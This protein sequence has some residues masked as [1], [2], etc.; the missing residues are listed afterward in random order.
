M[1]VIY[2]K[3]LGL[4]VLKI[5]I[6]YNYIFNNVKPVENSVGCLIIGC[7][8]FHNINCPWFLSRFFQVL[9]II[10]GMSRPL[11]NAVSHK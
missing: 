8:S 2:F 4:K 7:I 9:H 6:Y 5:S 3:V 11:L 1:M 10:D